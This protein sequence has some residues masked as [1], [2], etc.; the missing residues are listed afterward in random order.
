MKYRAPILRSEIPLPWHT[1]RF[2]RRHPGLERT[3]RRYTACFS[4]EMSS[5]IYLRLLEKGATRSRRWAFE[6]ARSAV[7]I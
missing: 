5:I 1:T 2:R 7:T 6:R 4:E 3:S